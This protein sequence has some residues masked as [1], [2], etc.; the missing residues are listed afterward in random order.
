M[1]VFPAGESALTIAHGDNM[2][3]IYMMGFDAWHDDLDKLSYLQ[4]CRESP[5]YKR[6]TWYVLESSGTPVSSLILYK[7]GFGLC[8]G[9]L[10]IGSIATHPAHRGRGRAKRLIE[11]V[12]DTRL[13]REA[14]AIYL[15]SDIGA[16]FYE[17]FGF[18]RIGGAGGQSLCMVRSSSS[19]YVDNLAVAPRYF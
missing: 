17:E 11:G 18:S 2:D 12:L 4:A 14:S 13:C 7:Q 6:G 8:T 5:K 10:G 16:G 3:V 9:A 15:H 1:S 19:E